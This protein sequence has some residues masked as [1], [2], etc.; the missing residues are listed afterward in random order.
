M[1]I[2]STNFAKRLVWKHEYDVNCDVTNRAHQI[3]MTTICHSTNPTHENFLRTP[4]VQIVLKHVRENA[5]CFMF[6]VSLEQ[7]LIVVKTSA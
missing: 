6:C 1:H 3:P 2:M 7:L 5:H 4:V